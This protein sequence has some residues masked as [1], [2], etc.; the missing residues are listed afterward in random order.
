MENNSNMFHYVTM[1]YEMIPN[2]RTLTEAADAASLV[3]ETSGDFPDTAPSIS[4]LQ[5]K[6]PE[7]D[8]SWDLRDPTPEG[9]CG[10]SGFHLAQKP[11]RTNGFSVP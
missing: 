2:K 1:V 11:C 5:D 6:I 7:E 4:L 10:P 8:G 9:N 3:L